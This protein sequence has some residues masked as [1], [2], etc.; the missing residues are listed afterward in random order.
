[1]KKDRFLMNIKK[2]IIPVAGMG[3]RFFPATKA[4]PKE[5]IPILKFPMIYYVIE[6]LCDAGI[7]ELV[8]VISKQKVSIENF[9]KID[10]SLADNFKKNNKKEEYN[11]LEKITKMVKIKT[12][13]QAEALGLGHAVLQAEKFIEKGENF[14]IVLPDDI[15]RSKKSVIGQLAE[16]SQK[17]NNAPVIGVMKIEKSQ[18]SKYGIVDGKSCDN[19]RMTMMTS[20]V[21]KPKPEDAPS[22]L[23][24]PGRYILSSDIFELL[25]NIPKGSGG[26]YQLTDAIN[27]LCKLRD[28]YAYEF[29]GERFDTGNIEGYLEATVEFALNDPELSNYMLELLQKKIEKYK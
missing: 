1:M 16:I 23:A 6:E 19:P 18:T 20:M 3:T 29:D 5:L 22:L 17:N 21:E 26:E 2:A 13:E 14:A 4:V 8:F 15:T 7:N 10:E 24:T 12:V 27:Q 11:L 25:K 28:V 9:F